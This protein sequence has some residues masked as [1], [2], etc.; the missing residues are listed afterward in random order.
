MR[1]LLQDRRIKSFVFTALKP[2]PS[3]KV[4]TFKD[5]LHRTHISSSGFTFSFV[6]D[7]NLD[8][9][10]VV[11]GCFSEMDASFG[12][13][14]FGL[15]LPFRPEIITVSQKNLTQRRKTAFTKDLHLHEGFQQ[16]KTHSQL[17]HFHGI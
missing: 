17:E 14:G 13:A 16:S 11:D 2:Q 4:L 1:F 9:A 10:V 15:R 8:L 3:A 5:Q 7:L 6:F 12:A